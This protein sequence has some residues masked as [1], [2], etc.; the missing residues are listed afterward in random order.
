MAQKVQVVLVDDVDGGSADETV[1]FGLD[2]V[3]Y[4]IDLTTKNAARLRDA[5][6][7]WVGSARKVSGP[8]GR[9]TTGRARARARRRQRR[10]P[11]LG[12]G[13]GHRGQRA[14]PHLRRPAREVRGRAL[15]EAGAA[16]TRRPRAWPPGA[17]GRHGRLRAR[18]QRRLPQLPRGGA[19]PGA[20]RSSSGRSR[21][22]SSW[23]AWP[24]TTG[25]RSPRLPAR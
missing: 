18:Q 4:E 25:A 10:D 20:S 13:R 1:T 21:T 5:F 19:R 12:Q 22:T 17:M 23:R 24:S 2:G 7:P 8:R 6:A 14:R 11:G 15:T 16:A 3:S 9:R